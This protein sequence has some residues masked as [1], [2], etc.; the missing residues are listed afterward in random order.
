MQRNYFENNSNSNNLFNI[1]ENYNKDTN[2]E[3]ISIKNLIKE[4]YDL[5]LKLSKLN[6]S[7]INNNII[8]PKIKKL[9]SLQ[10]SKKNLENNISEI[11]NTLSLEFKK[12]EISKEHKK[13]L[14]NE[15]ESKIIE[16]KTKMNLLNNNNNFNFTSFN[17]LLLIKYIYENKIIENNDFLSNQQIENII[18]KKNSLS[19]NDEIKK[20]F[21]EKEVLRLSQNIIEKNIIE[22]N[23]QKLQFEENLKM[24]DEEKSCILDELEDI[25]SYKESIENMIKLYIE[26][27]KKNDNNN[28]NNYDNNNEE[29]NE[30]VDILFDELKNIDTE[31]AAIKICDDL[32]D[33]FMLNQ[34]KESINDKFFQLNNNNSF[35]FNM[36]SKSKRND[37]FEF[38]AL[39][40][41][42]SNFTNQNRSESN[43]VTNRNIYNK[44]VVKNDDQVNLDKKM[45]KRLIQSEIDTFINTHKISEASSNY[46]QDNEKDLLNDF[47]FNLSMIII[48]KIKN[49]L[50]KSNKS[51]F[52]SENDIIIYLSFFFKSFYYE[53]IFDNNNQFINQDYN[54]I[55][56][57]IKKKLI[58]IE[59]E[60]VRLDT[61]LNEIKLKQ[62][63]NN[64]LEDLIIKK[65]KSNEESKCDEDYINLTKD[66]ITYIDICKEF[67]DL[68]EQKEK[69]INENEKN[70]NNFIQKKNDIE[71]KIEE[72][73][74]KISEINKEINEINKY[75]ENYTLKNNEE[76]ISYKKIMDDKINQIKLE[77]NLYKNKNQNNIDKC[78]DFY[79][80]INNIMK[81]LDL[82]NFSLD[83]HNNGN[84]NIESK[85]MLD[86]NENKYGLKTI[87]SYNY[88][89][90]YNTN[91][92]KIKEGYFKENKDSNMN[93]EIK[94]LNKS[95]TI[96]KTNKNKFSLYDNIYNNT[97][98]NSLIIKNQ[99]LNNSKN[100]DEETKT[101][102]NQ[103][104]RQKKQKIYN[105]YNISLMP[106][107]INKNKSTTNIH[108]K[109]KE[110][111]K[112]KS[113]NKKIPLSNKLFSSKNFSTILSESK[114]S[115][116]S[117]NSTKTIKSSYPHEKEKESDIINL[118][119]SKLDPLKKSIICYFREISLDENKN[120]I[121]Y[122]P[123]NNIDFDILCSSPYNFTRAKMKLSD[124]YD[125]INI[126]VYKDKNNYEIKIGDIENTVINSNI[127]KI[128]EIYRNYNK[129]K[130]RNNFSFEEFVNNEKNKFND[131]SKEDIIK[132][133]LNQ[134]FNFSLVTKKGKRIEFIIRSYDEFKIWI[135]GM[136][137]IVKNKNS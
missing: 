21:K 109:I 91:N 48:N 71:I 54:L 100:L 8:E 60:K 80:K 115:K 24:L 127:K 135:N 112:I 10:N 55:K 119:N 130:F 125:L 72:Y 15:I 108:A 110:I 65:N 45:L 73:N 86:E 92:K 67:N 32:Y 40:N 29:L 25:L 34:K 64:S 93:M 9:S 77:L 62:K 20:I 87:I 133:A 12:N 104:I 136:A 83:N 101:N 134:N 3:E 106:N 105:I 132:S 123:L 126:K 56:K 96:I 36:D 38:I 84:N 22:K 85:D 39:N 1:S 11:K 89:N 17:S 124:K 90:K 82:N 44:N 120:T 102:Y 28:D 70:N 50:S 49:I 23:I 69:I 26:K 52:I 94:K 98:N 118:Q 114:Q 33:L 76:I 95:M 81:S 88:Y 2:K 30:T 99:V 14:I 74:M 31:K 41:N 113:N 66:E 35:I 116:I 107:V 6:S 43:N 61:K 97:N 18:D 129:N 5:K 58:D 128:I 42:K 16:T 4:I 78:D 27:I 51:F 131:M 37:S 46:N 121:K 117:T 137:F 79:E 59:K 111:K 53:K 19:Y 7:K 103:P 75:M 68:N 122:N 63:I 13:V 57:E 47:L